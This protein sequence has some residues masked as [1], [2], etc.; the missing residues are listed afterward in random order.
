MNISA[1]LKSGVIITVI[2]RRG[3]R[4]YDPGAHSSEAARVVRFK[5]APHDN[6]SSFTAALRGEDA[7][8]EAFSPAALVH[9]R[10]IVRAAIA[11]GINHIITNEFGMDTFNSNVAEF[12]PGQ[13][14]DN[15]QRVLEEELQAAASSTQTSLTWT[16]IITSVCYDFTIRNR[17]SW[18]DA[19]ARTVTRY[20]SGNQKISLGREALC[21]EAVVTVLREPERF[22]NRPA[23]FASHTVSTNELIQLVNEVSEEPWDL[24]DVPDMVR[25]R[26]EAQRLWDEDT[27]NGVED[28]WNSRAWVMLVTAA[29]FD[30]QNRFG[31]DFAEKLEPACGESREEFKRY[32]NQLIEDQN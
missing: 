17:M 9:Q 2:N 25:F 15:A 13:A 11:A 30:E 8:I 31:M 28:R 19:A 7:L 27:R 3:G 10:T 6:E 18:L 26:G 1:L 5:E 14:K 16:G 32:L 4:G 23:Y 22:R 21:G 24:V 12:P 29:I 20:G